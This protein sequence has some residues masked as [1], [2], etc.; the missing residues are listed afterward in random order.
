MSFPPFSDVAWLPCFSTNQYGM[1]NF[2]RGSY[3]RHFVP[4]LMA[5]QPK[6]SIEFKSLNN[7][8]RGPPRKQSCEVWLTM[9]LWFMRRW[10]LKLKVNNRWWT[11]IGIDRLDLYM[12]LGDL[13]TLANKNNIL[14][15]KSLQLRWKVF[16]KGF[17]F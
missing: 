2:C 15:D 16:C 11:V 4:F 3:F 12:S 1:N 14:I 5:Q 17:S 6:F 10:C 9:I 8:E 7:F 13:K